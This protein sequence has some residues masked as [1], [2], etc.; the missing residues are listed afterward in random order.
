[1][2]IRLKAPYVGPLGVFAS[3]SELDL[4]AAQAKAWLELN[5]AEPVR[6]GAVERADA[7]PDAE[8]ATVAKKARSRKSVARKHKRTG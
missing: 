4:P 3:G 7:Q 1:M 5:L 6:A 2:L 8:K